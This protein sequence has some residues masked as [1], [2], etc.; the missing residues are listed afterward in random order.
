MMPTF[1]TLAS[2]S[3]AGIPMSLTVF[4]VAMALLLLAGASIAPETRGN[5]T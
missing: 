1:A 2:G 3:V 4:L 5:F